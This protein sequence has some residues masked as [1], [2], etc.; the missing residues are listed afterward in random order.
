MIAT[1]KQVPTLLF[2]RVLR[3]LYH[4][5][6]RGDDPDLGAVPRLFDDGAAPEQGQ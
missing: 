6:V 2:D 3:H 1:G 5:F 4:R